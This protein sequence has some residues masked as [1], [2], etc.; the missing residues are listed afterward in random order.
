MLLVLL[1]QLRQLVV[2]AM[3]RWRAPMAVKVVVM[4]WKPV[5]MVAVAL[6][7]QVTRVG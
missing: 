3:A 2:V 6:S 5:P 4:A 1:G 7:V